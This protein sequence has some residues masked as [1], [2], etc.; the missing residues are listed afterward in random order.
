MWEESRRKQRLKQ[1][2]WESM[3]AEV[4]GQQ[5]GHHARNA[6]KNV[7]NAFALIRHSSSG[8]R[9]RL[10]PQAWDLLKVKISWCVFSSRSLSKEY[11][12]SDFHLW[13][14]LVY[15][16]PPREGSCTFLLS[17]LSGTKEAC[18]VHLSISLSWCFKDFVRAGRVQLPQHWMGW[19]WQSCRCWHPSMLAFCGD[20]V[21]CCDF[22]VNHSEV[23][24]GKRHFSLGKARSN[25][26]TFHIDRAH[27]SSSDFPL[28]LN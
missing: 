11:D 8:L 26:W 19:R 2:R 13:K 27:W 17:P 4:W 21:D 25:E 18:L 28:L 15:P 24:F 7:R 10:P 12:Q 6:G 14:I 5:A 20:H 1:R 16:A 23:C 22:R 9:G 3:L